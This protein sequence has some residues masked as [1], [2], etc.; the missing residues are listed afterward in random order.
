[1]VVFLIYTIQEN[2]TFKIFPIYNKFNKCNTK[3]AQKLIYR[4]ETSF[5]KVA[6][7]PLFRLQVH[8]YRITAHNFLKFAS[9][10]NINSHVV[11]ETH[12]QCQVSARPVGRS[13]LFT[14]VFPKPRGTGLSVEPQRVISEAKLN[15]FVRPSTKHFPAPRA[16]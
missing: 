15:I 2:H 6:H 7:S 13:Q 8:T 9:N 16:T 4:K 3:F 5:R 1:M 12:T 10:I 14:C 11:R